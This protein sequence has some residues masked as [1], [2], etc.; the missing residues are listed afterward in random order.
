M[1]WFALFLL[2]ALLPASLVLRRH[3]RAR[4]TELSARNEELR[5]EV[6]RRE[7]A[8]AGLRASEARF[9]RVL[10]HAAD[11]FF[12][13][14][15][16]GRFLDV[17]L[18]A[19]QSLGY[20]RDEL[21]RLSVADVS[22][23]YDR[24]GV[25][26]VLAGL[27]AEG[28]VTIDDEHR[29]MDGS[30]FPAEVRID[31]IQ[32]DDEEL[33]LS[34]A[35]DVTERRS[36]EQALRES[37]AQLQSTVDSLPFDFVAVD[38]AGRYILQNSI[39][40]RR[41]GDIIGKRPED[42]GVREE[43]LSLWRDNN[44]RVL[45]GETVTGEAE[46]TV[47][48]EKLVC[49]SIVAP[50]RDGER[51]I[52]MLA[53][54]LDISDRKQMEQEARDA[55]ER[56]SATLGALPDLLFEVDR[57]G[58]IL[59]YHAPNSG[60]LFVPREG[61]LGKTVAEV[62]PEKAAQVI[63]AAID[64]AAEEGRHLGAAYPL[65]TGQGLRWFELSIA[66]KGEAGSADPR[67]IVLIRDIT[68]RKLLEGQFLQAQKMEAVGTL[69]SGIAHDFNNLLQV[70]S[71]HVQIMLLRGNHGAG[72]ETR[73]TEIDQTVN[74]AAH[75][76]RQLLAFSR[77]QKPVLK[78]VDLNEEIRGTVELL[79]RTIPKM[80]RIESDLDPEPQWVGADPNQLEHVLM[81]LGTNA[82]DAMPEG[83]NLTIQT[84]TV[85]LDADY[86]AAHPETEPGEYVRLR[87]S[88]DGVGMDRETLEHI[89]DPFFTT[90]EVGK[91][92]GL[93]LS[94]VYGIIGNHGGHVTCESEWDRGTTFRIYLP[95]FPEDVKAAVIGGRAPEVV[96][97]GDE[98]ILVVDDERPVLD[99]IRE[100][101]GNHGYTVLAAEDGEQALEIFRGDTR[102]DLVILDIGM[103]GMG[104]RACL[105]ELLKS[106]PRAKVI[107]AS[108]YSSDEDAKEALAAGATGFV[109]K[110]YRVAELFGKIRDLLDA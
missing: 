62:I 42:V 31:R 9:R 94:T 35:R 75:L 26:R 91:G 77:A 36:A 80:I 57:Q 24:E 65:E 87:F 83:G 6:A 81:N 64:E 20:T 47:G 96:R 45:S 85:T 98:T 18:Q 104:G 109:A 71:G 105:R 69:A 55:H 43:L 90:K 10:E 54:N 25:R 97:G 52:G 32:M 82:R 66:A 79:Q 23:R 49:Q 19:C 103:P 3:V 13:H 92:T 37:R 110:P 41:W 7:E 12:L 1:F 22:V 30:T 70:I 53:V 40:K 93:G 60:Q 86:C 17:N 61:F 89:F 38:A 58:R 88:D 74:R 11:A 67:F 59:N 14:D 48:G 108:G 95:V 100:S 107:I 106:D 34:I 72:V 21:L 5:R 8:E 76:V 63:T 15:L 27:G 99:L 4:T 16:E 73:L 56:L 2:M 33:A 39:C 46:Y 28:P 68:K 51:I 44:R 101:L 102:V 84:R 29:R 50:I 78:P